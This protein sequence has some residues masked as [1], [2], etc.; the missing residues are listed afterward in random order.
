MEGAPYVGTKTR[1]YTSEH[2]LVYEDS[3]AKWPYSFINDQ[4]EPD[5]FNIELVRMLMQHL[6]IPYEI[7]LRNQEKVHEDLRRDSA[8][9][10]FGVAA[11]YNAEFGRFGRVT[12]TPFVNGIMLF[13]KDSIGLVTLDKLRSMHF[14]VR[15]E[16][17]ALYYLQEHDF[18]DSVINVVDN[19]EVEILERYAEGEVGAMWNTMMLKWVINKYHLKDVCVT[20]VDIPVGDYRIMSGDTLLLSRLDSVVSILKEKG[21][22]E[23]LENKWMYPEKHEED[24]TYLYIILISIAVFIIAIIINFVV[25]YYQ[26][27]H[28]R[29]TLRDVQQQ[30]N[31]VMTSNNM[32]V[33]V[34]YPL[35]RRYA[36]MSSEGRVENEYV[37]FEFSRFY[38]DDDFN[39]IHTHVMEFLTHEDSRQVTCRL[40]TYASAESHEILE[41][42]VGINVMRDDYGK[43]FLVY[44]VEHNI[45]GSEAV[46]ESLRTLYSQQMMAFNN[47]KGSVIWFD[48]KGNVIDV[49]DR[50]LLK[51]GATREEILSLGFTIDDFHPFRDVDFTDGPDDLSFVSCIDNDAMAQI[52][53]FTDPKFKEVCSKYGNNSS[54]FLSA[55]I[56]HRSD[57][58]Y[59]YVH[60][61]K[62]HNKAGEL[63]SYVM[64]LHDIS[65]YVYSVRECNNKQRDNIHL[66]TEKNLYHKRR[67]YVIRE[68]GIEMVRYYPDKKHL[69][70]YDRERRSMVAYSQLRILELIDS[71]DMK[72]IFK[73]FH[74]ADALTQKELCFTVRTLLRNSKGMQRHF[75]ITCY[76]EYN[77]A[78]NITSYFAICR[79]ITMKEHVQYL[80]Q[81]ETEKAREAELVKQNFL[82]N[83]SYSIRQ[84]LITM[85]RYIQTLPNVKGS[86]EL[87]LIKGLE[88]N[89]Q[90]L[91]TLSDDTLMLSRIE[92]GMLTPMISEFDF[93]KV[94]RQSINDGLANYRVASV[95]YNIQD[96]YDTLK[97]VSDPQLVARIIR[98][99][100]ALSAR[101]TSF[102]TVNIRYIHRHGRLQI[103]IED[104]GQ[105]ISPSVMETLYEP[106]IGMSY[107]VLENDLNVSGL[108]MAICKA[109]V[110][111]LSGTIEV[112]SEPGRGTSIYI[113]LPVS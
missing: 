31:L 92:A 112:E 51:T 28:S 34:Y 35:T 81:Q 54:N 4:G 68:S 70:F 5:G 23:R 36:W 79:D 9:I 108:E 52:I 71:H 89:T 72:R 58:G 26:K 83:M 62:S 25:R 8:D 64:Y 32:R 103:A 107:N 66:T 41:I 73:L 113:I 93:V 65:E 102:G 77:E 33:W 14:Y 63:I 45:T 109:L 3:W 48:A 99:A 40:R 104:T 17:R 1:E 88:N 91:I 47:A 96:T 67:N 49:N 97:I 39:I 85:Q 101:Y 21:E 61:L 84:P 59:Y 105:G 82:R 55:L 16:S 19:M 29:S 90:R 43:I 15:K 7:R 74:K 57:R 42:E 38:P 98:E 87:P 111:M 10:S 95:V 27:Y 18:P 86:D 78:G 6:R 44:G 12:V 106:N 30:L 56:T 60:M 24:H 110:E 53:A 100:V 13:K 80:L 22:L 46:L 50:I 76:P 20:K 37:S 75:Y 94:Y 69:Y 11:K 2:P